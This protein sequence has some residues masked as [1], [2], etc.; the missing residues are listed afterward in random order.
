MRVFSRAGKGRDL[1]LRYSGPE[2]LRNT[3]GE[4][5][6]SKEGTVDVLGTIR[7]MQKVG[8]TG[9]I[10][11]NAQHLNDDVSTHGITAQFA[12][13]ADGRIMATTIGSDEYDVRY[14]DPVRS[15]VFI[16]PFAKDFETPLPQPLPLMAFDGS[17]INHHQILL[18]AKWSGAKGFKVL[19]AN[20]KLVSTFYL[21]R[22]GSLQRIAYTSATSNTVTFG[23]VDPS[24]SFVEAQRPDVD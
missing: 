3:D 2:K 18:D 17:R 21:L 4:I 13:L 22:D 6:Y 20:G 19:D 8:A 16:G 11:A 9:F 10:I 23:N 1:T 7:R 5:L 15:L 24:G 12:T 14:Y